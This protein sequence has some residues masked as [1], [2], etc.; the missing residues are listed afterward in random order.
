MPPCFFLTSHSIPMYCD[1]GV[2]LFLKSCNFYPNQLCT[3]FKQ[4]VNAGGVPDEGIIRPVTP[5]SL[6]LSTVPY[7]PQ[8]SPAAREKCMLCAGILN[9]KCKQISTNRIN[10]LTQKRGKRIISIIR[11]FPAPC[12]LEYPVGEI[13][14]GFLLRRE[15]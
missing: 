11:T 12:F 5:V 13:R 8:F 7:T 1:A 10:D 15:S 14:L 2:F 6:R 4:I 9:Y 3:F